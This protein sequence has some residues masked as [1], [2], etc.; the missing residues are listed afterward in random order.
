MQTYSRSKERTRAITFVLTCVVTC[1]CNAT[2]VAD[3]AAILAD[4]F[5][6]CISEEFLKSLDMHLASVVK[7]RAMNIADKMA[8]MATVIE[9]TAFVFDEEF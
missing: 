7:Y 8:K 3:N 1:V 4:I 5:V 9:S 2:A 6:T